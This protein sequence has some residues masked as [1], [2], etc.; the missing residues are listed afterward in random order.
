[1]NNNSVPIFY[2]NNNQFGFCNNQNY[3]NMMNMNS[4]NMITNNTNTPFTFNTNQTPNFQNFNNFN[5]I[6]F[7]Q[8]SSN[9]NT[10][11]NNTPFSNNNSFA[12]NKNSQNKDN[13]VAPNFDLL[14]DDK[15]QASYLFPLVGLENVGLTCYMNSALQCL[16]HI[17]ELNNYFLNIYNNQKDILKIINKDAET[18]GL[19][20]ERYYDLIIDIQKNNV[21]NYLDA[22]AITPIFFHN[23][24]VILNPQFKEFD[25]NDSKDLLLFLFQSMHEELNYYGNKKLSSIP[26]CNQGIAQEALN[27]FWKV[28]NTLN[29]SIFSY[30]FY[31]IFETETECLFCNYKFYNFQY[32]QIITFPLYNYINNCQVYNIYRGFKDF[33][34]KEKMSGNNQCYC[35]RCKQLR[36]CEVGSLIYLTPPYLIINL[37][38][39]KDKR[40]NPIGFN[41]GEIL[42][43]TGFTEEICTERNYKLVAVSTHIGTSGVSGHYIAYCKNPFQQE[44]DSSWYKFNDSCVSKVEFNEVK[45][46]SPYFLIFKKNKMMKY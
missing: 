16:L 17:P 43:L 5:N 41:F 6:S 28:N 22:K 15:N 33:I 46:N 9:N 34:K 39:G 36:D 37:D 27:F 31:G 23:T 19:L 8:L 42:D 45:Q 3:N 4:M 24:I 26:T 21:Q 13:F 30:L 44:N 25:A 2:N 35:Q 12:N 7:N 10:N 29:L 18:K 32:F 11:F 14:I 40:Y 1:M 20:S 38:Y